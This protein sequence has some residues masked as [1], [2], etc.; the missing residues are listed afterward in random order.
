M[1]ELGINTRQITP[2]I[3]LEN[4]ITRI[5]KTLTKEVRKYSKTLKWST[6]KFNE[7]IKPCIPLKVVQAMKNEDDEIFV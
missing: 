4:S 7:R 1:D 2:K 3:V 6:F 5:I